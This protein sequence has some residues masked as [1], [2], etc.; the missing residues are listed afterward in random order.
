MS[1]TLIRVGLVPVLPQI[2]LCVV[3]LQTSVT[4]AYW[5]SCIWTL[6]YTCAVL[7]WG[8]YVSPV[9]MCVY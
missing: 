1:Q 5:V 7:L 2:G 6:M 4:S 9:A 8:G 3:T